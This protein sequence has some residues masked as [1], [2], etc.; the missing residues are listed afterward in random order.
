MGM[1]DEV[2]LDCPWCNDTNVEQTKSGPCLL[3]TYPLNG[4]LTTTAG[5]VGDHYCENCHKEFTVR[6][7]TRPVA[8]IVKKE[9]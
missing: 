7:K 1:F 5:V 3:R 6:W 4:E 2:L 9:E 8:E